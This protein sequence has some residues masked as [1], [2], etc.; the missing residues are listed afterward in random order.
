M[1]I[2]I[3]SGPALVGNVGT[4]KR[5]NY[6]AVGETVNLASRLES[7][8]E[9]YSCPVVIGPRSAELVTSEF[10]LRELDWLLVKGAGAHLAVY[11]PIV[12]RAAASVRQVANAEQFAEALGCYRARRFADA[13]AIWED[14]ARK[15]SEGDAAR[16]RS[17]SAA[18]DNPPAAM[19]RRARG[20]ISRPP[21]AGW[22]GVYISNPE[23]NDDRQ[24]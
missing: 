15:E 19:A 20:L 13:V 11:E 3:N 22:D 7:A 16:D 5:Y 12:E 23:V 4:E 10:L 17:N 21:A 9:I 1:K 14:L 2:G 24:S 8:P 6:T 18:P